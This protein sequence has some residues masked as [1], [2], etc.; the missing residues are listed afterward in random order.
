MLLFL[1]LASLT[2]SEPRQKEGRGL[3]RVGG[4]Q[5]SSRPPV[6]FIA[7]RPQAALLVWF[8]VN[9]DVARCYLWLFTLYINTKISKNSGFKMLD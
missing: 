1:A 8:F 9:L 5:T 4:P 6:I 7:G 3:A 2:T